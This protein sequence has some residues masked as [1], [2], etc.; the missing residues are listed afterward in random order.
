M[1]CS[2]PGSSVHGILQTRKLEWVAMLSSRGIFP[3]QGSNPH[4]L[5]PELAGGLFI[6]MPAGKPSE[7]TAILMAECKVTSAGVSTLVGLGYRSL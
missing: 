1:D 7:N 6:A 5:S 2:P 4:L 3:T